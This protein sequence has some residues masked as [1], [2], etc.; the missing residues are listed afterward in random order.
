M[1]FWGRSAAIATAL[2]IALLI[3]LSLGELFVSTRFESQFQSSKQY[4]TQTHWLLR[5]ERER[6]IMVEYSG[7]G[8]H[9]TEPG[10]SQPQ[11][12][13]RLQKR[14]PNEYDEKKVIWVLSDD[15]GAFFYRLAPNWP[16]LF[17][18]LSL[19]SIFLLMPIFRLVN[20]PNSSYVAPGRIGDVLALI[21]VLA[22]DRLAHR[23]ESGLNAELQG[24]PLSSKS[25]T[26]IAAAHPEF[27]RVKSSGENVVS[28]LARHTSELTDEG[29]EPLS[30]EYVSS[31]LSLAV[32][33]HDRETERSR[34]WQV[35]VPLIVAL[36]AG[37]FTLVG[38][39][40]K[41]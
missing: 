28:L 27:F 23:S 25:W 26:E 1:H 12:L 41:K 5:G 20:R 14:Y 36:V 10:V 32:E 30:V 35:W 37:I 11:I 21:Q 3:A 40:L 24:A 22:F 15:E 8:F 6:G 29:R 19:S 4:A 13:E 31:L 16:A 39:G 18:A 7:H 33:L 34:G 38:S 9:S 17:F 2:S